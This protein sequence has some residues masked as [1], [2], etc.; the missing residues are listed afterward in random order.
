MLRHTRGI[1]P[2]FPRAL[3]S[4]TK[5]S[6]SAENVNLLNCLGKHPL[7]LASPSLQELP[8]YCASGKT[9]AAEVTRLGLTGG[10]VAVEVAVW[11]WRGRGGVADWEGEERSRR[12][13]V[14]IQGSPPPGALHRTR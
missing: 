8:P 12:N 5:G 4:R 6:N 1:A 14:S 10:S 13:R 2:H 9:K 7:G 3:C 11:V